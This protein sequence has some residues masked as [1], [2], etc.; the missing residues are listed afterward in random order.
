MKCVAWLYYYSLVFFIAFV[1]AAAAFCGLQKT[2]LCLIMLF[3]HY[4]FFAVANSKHHCLNE[5]I[6]LLLFV[7]LLLPVLQLGNLCLQIR[8]FQENWNVR[9]I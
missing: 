7:C 4:L 8:S 9:T 6:S 1:A 3:D 2:V 5:A